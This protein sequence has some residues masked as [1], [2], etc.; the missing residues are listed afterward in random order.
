L[1]AHVPLRWDPAEQTVTA[2]G[3]PVYAPPLPPAATTGDQST[4][5]E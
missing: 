1:A 5:C 4:L 3:A 2:G